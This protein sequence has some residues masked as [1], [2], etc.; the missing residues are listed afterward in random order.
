MKLHQLIAILPSAKKKAKEG[1]TAAYQNAQRSALFQGISRT[2]TPR[3][4]DGYVY[5]SESSRV[6]MTAQQLIQRF[7]DATL[8]F[9][10]LAATQDN[11]NTLASADVSVGDRQ[12]LTNVPVTQL[13]FLEKQLQDIRTFVS[14]LPVLPI[15]REWSYEPNKGCYQTAPVSTAS[16]KKITEFVVAY[17][18]TP[19]HPA[20]IR[21]VTKDT[22]V[23]TWSKVD[24]SGALPQDRV[25]GLL[26]NVDA[27]LSAV[28]KARAEA[29]EEEVSKQNSVAVLSFIFGDMYNSDGTQS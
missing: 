24:L 2:Y 23:G 14:A 13:L 12:V 3:D 17:D 19:E 7:C 1:Q 9:F 25:R 4:E 16:T 20:Q 27:L 11:A 6:T 18:A 15:D 10:N 21:E 28:V 26:D 8:D 29:N 22:V 5:P